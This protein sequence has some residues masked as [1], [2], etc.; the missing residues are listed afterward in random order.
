[1][2]AEKKSGKQATKGQKQ[3]AEEN[4]ATLL[5]YRNMSLA[6]ITVYCSACGFLWSS[7]TTTDLVC[8]LHKYVLKLQTNTIFLKVLIC[9][10]AFAQ[11]CCHRLM[12]YM[13]K[14]KRSETGQLLDGGTDLNMESGISEHIKDAI[15]LTSVSEILA[16]FSCYFWLLLLVV[17]CR[18]FFMLWKNILGPYFFQPAPT[19]DQ[20]EVN[21]KKQK[22][23]ERR[24]KRSQN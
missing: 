13:A 24:L 1:M 7:V 16:S 2:T 9:L 21:E 17:P 15:I 20:E 19:A 23:M 14:T 5:F 12:A 4:V 8:H 18:L 11:F 10:C 6:A 3:I 22:K